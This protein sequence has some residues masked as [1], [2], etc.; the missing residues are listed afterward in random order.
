MPT[1]HQVG[2]FLKQHCLH[3]WRILSGITS[4]VS[5]PHLYAIYRKAFHRFESA[6][7]H[8]T[9]TIAIHCTHWRNTFETIYHTLIANVACM[10]YLIATAEVLHI[11]IVPPRMRIRQYSYSLHLLLLL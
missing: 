1:Y 10:P 3:A 8:S 4:Y 5:H 6:T 9:I 7:H 11:F 2:L